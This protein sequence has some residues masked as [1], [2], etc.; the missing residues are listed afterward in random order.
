MDTYLQD[1]NA[2]TN[3][4]GEELEVPTTIPFHFKSTML[5]N[6][7]VKTPAISPYV[8]RSHVGYMQTLL[9]KIPFPNVQLVPFSQQHSDPDISNKQIFLHHTLCKKS[10]AVKLRDTSKELKLALAH[11]IQ[12]D[13]VVGEHIINMAT[14]A[15]GI[16]Y[17][18]CL[19]DQKQIV[20]EYVQ[21]F[22]TAYAEQHPDNT[23]AS[24]VHS[25]PN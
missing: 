7:V 25:R 19:E 17:I 21:E 1:P 2:V 24:I 9:A 4:F 23:T 15:D 5:R 8:G 13:E 10:Q 20:T 22:L 12:E 16:L 6:K 18:Q 14:A 3:I 11:K